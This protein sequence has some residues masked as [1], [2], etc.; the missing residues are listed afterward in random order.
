MARRVVGN[1]AFFKLEG[2]QAVQDAIKETITYTQAHAIKEVYLTAAKV[3]ANEIRSR[4]PFRANEQRYGKKTAW[5]HTRDAIV[6]GGVKN[7]EPNVL[8]MINRRK[9]PQSWWYE[10]GT[11]KHPRQPARPFF[12][13]A[14]TA[15]RATIKALISDGLKAAITDP[16]NFT[17]VRPLL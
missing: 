6:I 14:I 9:A 16:D 1:K 15:Q 5:L 17:R 4:A 7:N 10:Y 3:L 11:P 13:P 12:R 2:V 8:V